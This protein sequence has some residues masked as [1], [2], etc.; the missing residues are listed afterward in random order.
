MCLLSTQVYC[1]EWP[2]EP[3]DQDISNT[4]QIVYHIKKHFKSKK[5]LAFVFFLIWNGKKKLHSETRSAAL[6]TVHTET[7][8]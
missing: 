7:P 8:G 6:D 4:S 5:I 3:R 1:H 2:E